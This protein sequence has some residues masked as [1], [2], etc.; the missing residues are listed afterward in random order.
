MLKYGTQASYTE[1]LLRRCSCPCNVDTASVSLPLLLLKNK[2]ETRCPTSAVQQKRT[3]LISSR[4]P[5]CLSCPLAASSGYLLFDVCCLR[6]ITH[7]LFS[8]SFDLNLAWLY[9]WL[10]LLVIL[11]LIKCHLFKE[12]FFPLLCRSCPS[13]TLCR[14]PWAY[15]CHILCHRVY[16]HG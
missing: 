11:L 9:A 5:S 3:F 16:L 6:H 2:G 8:C 12:L 4:L 14:I 7:A 10:V 1:L 15:L 13:V